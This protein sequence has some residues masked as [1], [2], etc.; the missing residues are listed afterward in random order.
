MIRFLVYIPYYELSCSKMEKPYSKQAAKVV[1]ELMLAVETI[2][3]FGDT[4]ELRNVNIAKEDL[5][6]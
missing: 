6:K 3:H 4:S 1:Q 2:Q 5:L